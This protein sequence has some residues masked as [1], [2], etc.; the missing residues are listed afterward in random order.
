MAATPANPK[1]T[2]TPTSGDIHFGLGKCWLGKALVAQSQQG[3]CAILLGDDA[4]VLLRDLQ[5]RFPGEAITKGGTEFSAVVASVVD[6]LDHPEKPLS[7]PLDIRGTAFQK[8][9]WQALTEVPAG[10][11]VSY[12]DLAKKLGSGASAVRAIAGACAANALAVAI[13][14][15]RAVKNDGGLAGFRWGLE[16]KR[17]LLE[18]E[19]SGII[20]RYN[21]GA[22]HQLSLF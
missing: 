9:V 18:K 17:A 19:G 15:H 2:L 16:R 10:Q 21:K 5:D 12:S 4:D 6:F 1:S 20:G 14:C 22:V 7:L 3:I 13:P 8:Q 11:T